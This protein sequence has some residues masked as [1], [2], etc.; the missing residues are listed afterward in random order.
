[1]ASLGA[2]GN[3]QAKPVLVDMAPNYVIDPD[4]IE[5]AITPKTK[6][7]LP[8]HFCGN[9]C[10]MDKIMAVANKHN[11]PVIEDA[12]QAYLA[13]WKG[14]CVGNFGL[15]GAFS[16]HPLKILNVWGDGGVITTNDEKFYQEAK[17][18]QNHGME[19]RDN[20][21]RFPC[22]NSRLD[23]IHAAVGNAQIDETPANVELRRNNAKFY[24]EAFKSVAGVRTV[25]RPGSVY[26]LYFIEVA[27][28][29][30][31]HL[32]SFL[33]QSGIECKIH[34]RLPL[35]QQPGLACLGYKPG[36]FPVADQQAG[37]YITLPVDE[38]V[39]DEMRNYVVKKVAEFM[40]GARSW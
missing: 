22:R 35:Y 33:E 27:A 16:L 25:D 14:K 23:A 32:Y 34:Y 39:T 1:V 11:L 28:G 38:L 21:T 37:R 24:D 30:R 26:H 20:I 5:A 29:V 2:I 9:P 3:L 19:T 7:I 31:D 10:D 18:L 12:C 15:A 40:Q 13:E 4:L 17:L 8:V 36:D 6:A